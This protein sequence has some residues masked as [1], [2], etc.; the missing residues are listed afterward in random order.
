MCDIRYTTAFCVRHRLDFNKVN[1][2]W[3][4]GQSY[5]TFVDTCYTTAF[6]VWHRWDFNWSFIWRAA[7]PFH[8]D[9]DLTWRFVT[10][11]KTQE[12]N[13][14]FW[15]NPNSS[16]NPKR[17]IKLQTSLNQ[18]NTILSACFLTFLNSQT[19]WVISPVSVSGFKSHETLKNLALPLIPMVQCWG[20]IRVEWNAND[21]TTKLVP[22]LALLDQLCFMTCNRDGNWIW[23]CLN[24]RAVSLLLSMAEQ[25]A[26]KGLGYQQIENGSQV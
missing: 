21:S 10:E 16:F 5:D 20:R 11:P 13:G 9:V 25:S 26:S 18:G 23:D 17:S 2:R 12:K 24:G 3:Q 7:R 19:S 1:I 8:S 4:P 22:I 6:C 14:Q 15:N